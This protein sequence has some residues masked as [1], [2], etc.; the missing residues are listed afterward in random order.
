MARGQLSDLQRGTYGVGGE[1]LDYEWY[2]TATLAA[3]TTVHH[4]FSVGLGGGATPKTLDATNLNVGGAVPQ[5][6]NWTVKRIKAFF[7]TNAAVGTAAVQNLYTMLER[8]TLEFIIPGKDNLLACTLNIIMGT[9][10]QFALTPTVAGDNIPVIQPKYHG[11]Y[12]LSVPI[13]LAALTP[14]EIRL[15]HQTAVA[16]ALADC[17]LKISLSGVLRRA[18]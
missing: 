15:T 10:T 1:V 3:A 14:F 8:T 12:P 5:G 16:A 13:V 17:R 2:D 6:Q 9:A 4:L 18:A 7:S 11:I